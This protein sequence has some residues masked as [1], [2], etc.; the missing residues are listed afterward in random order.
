MSG[1][2][3]ACGVGPLFQGVLKLSPTCIACGL[4]LKKYDQDDGPAPFAIF[5]VGIICMGG[6]LWVE[7]NLYPPFWVHL[8]VWPPLIFGL[9]V[10][11]LRTLKAWMVQQQYKNLPLDG[12]EDETSDNQ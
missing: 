4:E 9:T 2:C 1:R 7:F 8:V 5:L 10:L 12:A 11:C 6:A 3:P